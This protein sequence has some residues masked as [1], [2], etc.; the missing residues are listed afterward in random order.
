MTP[1]PLLLTVCLLFAAAGCSSPLETA[2]AERFALQSIDGE[3]LPAVWTAHEAGTTEILADTLAL[4]GNGR[5]MRSVTYRSTD[6]HGQ[7]TIERAEETFSYEFSLGAIEIAFDCNDVIIR[8]A[9][10][11]APP[12]MIGRADA[13]RLEVIAFNAR[14]MRYW[15]P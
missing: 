2:P 5:G 3:P 8:M 14:Q 12:H 4:D 7:E 15:R 10:C 9:S 1:R 13:E 6:A 11:V